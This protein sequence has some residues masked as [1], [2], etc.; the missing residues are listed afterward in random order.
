M[1]LGFVNGAGIC[2][3]CW[4]LSMVLGFVNGAGICQWC[5]DLSM[6]LG[7]VYGAG[8]CLWCWDLAQTV[9]Q[10]L[11]NPL[12]YSSNPQFGCAFIYKIG[13]AKETAMILFTST[14]L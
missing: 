1:V 9:R 12:R 8:I 13:F 10:K 5:W 11:A 4:D 2:L 7:F 6:V 14:A 3:W